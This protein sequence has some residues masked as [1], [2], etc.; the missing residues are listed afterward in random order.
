MP[1]IV[2][3]GAGLLLGIPFNLMGN[4]LAGEIVLG[5]FAIAGVLMN[6]NNPGFLDR[7]L[8]V[9]TSLF[10][11]SL[12]VYVATDFALQTE[13]HNAARGW[14][15]FVFLIV[16][17]VGLYVIA[18]KSRKSLFPIFIGYMLAQT[19]IWLRPQP[20]IHGY[21][22]VWKHHLCLPVLAGSLCLV[23]KPF[24][25][26][27]I[28]TAGGTLSFLIDTRAFG[29]MC[30]VT[31]ALLMARLVLVKRIERLMP[32]VLTVSL[33]VCAL[34]V[35]A[36]LD[37]THDQ[38]GKRQLGSNELRYAAFL[39]AWQSIAI[40]PWMGIGSWKTDFEA[41]NRHRANLIEAGGKHD[42]ETYDQ[43]GH[44]QILQTWLEGGPLAAFAFFYLLWRMLRALQWTLS[45]PV[46]RFLAF[47][48]FILLN[49]IWSCLF[50]PF[51]GADVRVNTAIAIYVCISLARERT[52]LMRASA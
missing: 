26:I 20:D 51:L 39:T 17:F 43:S 32:V 14:A 40:N 18:R 38:F 44:S 21:I 16:D 13:L 19:V 6:F 24:P 22:T 49:G 34:G 33:I 29:T 42:T 48:I 50:S 27:F 23:R 28:L 25:S 31:A 46:D 52:N 45:R 47:A 36:F 12:L 3:F 4:L 5:I 1:E 8:I 11:L 15:R 35:N 7:K 9:F 10:A 41:A 37:R 2:L 30:F